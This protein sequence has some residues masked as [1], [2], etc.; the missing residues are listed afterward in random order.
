MNTYLIP[1]KSH[2]FF[3]SFSS[4]DPIQIFSYCIC[5]D[6]FLASSLNTQFDWALYSPLL[7][8]DIYVSPPHLGCS[9]RILINL[10]GFCRCFTD[11][12]VDMTSDRLENLFL[13]VVYY[14]LCQKPSNTKGQAIYKKFAVFLSFWLE[15]NAIAI[16]CIF[17]FC[18]NMPC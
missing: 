10:F 8:S 9:A 3:F 13:L 17:I 5:W 16:A 1:G 12:T 15:A 4:S 14:M 11:T 2:V 7:I 6:F 18:L